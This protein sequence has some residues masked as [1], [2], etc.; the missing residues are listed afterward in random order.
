[1]TA[2]GRRPPGR[3]RSERSHL[4]I[5]K[6]TL[7]LLVEVGYARI[8]MEEVQRRAGVGKA[9]IYRRWASKEELVK[10]AI[11]HFSAELPVPDTGSLKGDYAAISTA[12][13]AIARDRN[14]ALV[15]PRLL[16]E[17]SR[18]PD[19]HAIFYAQL[20]EPRRR[21]AR[22]ALE[23]ARDRG[24]LRE[25]VDLELTIDMLAGPIVYRFLITGGDLAPAAAVAP[26][27]LDALLEGLSPPA[28]GR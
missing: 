10:D 20:V 13:V 2:V 24:E 3:P 27:L 16:A 9:T 25:D 12:L 28:P 22:I 8:T 1:M 4:A 7:E 11:Q 6:A 26:R 14:A 23:R 19:L 17:A 5:V 18:D 21:V 15:M